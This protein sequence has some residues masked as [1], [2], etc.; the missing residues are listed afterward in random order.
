M[1]K[2]MG[3]HEK[4]PHDDLIANVFYTVIAAVLLTFYLTS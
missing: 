2:E 3:S 1:K 4:G